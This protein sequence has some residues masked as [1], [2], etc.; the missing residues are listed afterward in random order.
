MLAIRAVIALVINIFYLGWELKAVMIDSIDHS[1]KGALALR[2]AI[3][4]VGLSISHTSLKYF[5]ITTV[6]IFSNLSPLMVVAIGFFFC[7]ET[8]TRAQLMMMGLALT[9]V[10]LIIYGS[11]SDSKSYESRASIFAWSL[12]FLIPFI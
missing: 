11:N 9:A 12:L 3:S 6:S 5:S 2:V 1:A 10:F 8:I 4:V 7:A